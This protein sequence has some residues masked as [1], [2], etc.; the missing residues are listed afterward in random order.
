VVQFRNAGPNFSPFQ[1]GFQ[2]LCSVL[3]ST[4]EILEF[5]SVAGL[6]ALK[7]IPG[8]ALAVVYELSPIEIFLTLFIGGMAGIFAFSYFGTRIR[9]WR[10]RRRMQKG[11][12]KPYKIRR[13]RRIMRIWRKFGLAG[14]ALLTPPMI[15]PPFGAIIAVAFGERLERILIFMAVSMAIWAGLFALLGNQILQWIG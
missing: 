8:A 4:M 15:S 14:V 2:Y 13:I 3:N 11:I 12:Q 6:S 9:D 7:V 1:S 10:K 5:L